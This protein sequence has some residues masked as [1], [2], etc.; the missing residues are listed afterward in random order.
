MDQFDSL[1]TPMLSTALPKD[2]V[3]IDNDITPFIV[4]GRISEPTGPDFLSASITYDDLA[5]STSKIPLLNDDCLPLWAL[6]GSRPESTPILNTRLWQ[7][8]LY[9]KRITRIEKFKELH[10]DIFPELS[11]KQMAF[12]YFNYYTKNSTPHD[13]S[14]EFKLWD[15]P[16][17][18]KDLVQRRIAQTI[19]A[20][21]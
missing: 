16:E 4:D 2:F 6:Q 5:N 17:K 3:P 10:R 19:L 13:T 18:I 7:N 1:A 21:H 8:Q 15:A 14:T 20:D 9:V 12:V 11:Q